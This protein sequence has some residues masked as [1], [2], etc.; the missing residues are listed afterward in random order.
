MNDKRKLQILLTVPSLQSTASP[1]RE[2]HAIA[3]FL[4]KDIFDLSICSLR[5][6]G[7]D[8][9]KSLFEDCGVKNIFKARYRINRFKRNHFQVAW[10]HQKIFQEYGP[11]DL[12]HSLDFSSSPFEPIMTMLKR[13]IY[14]FNQRDLVLEHPIFHR[15]KT[16]FSNKVIAISRAVENR[17]VELGV[18]KKKIRLIINGIDFQE[19]DQRLK[20]NIAV[21]DGLITF[22]G[23]IMPRKRHEDA[24]RTIAAL[25]DSG[26][27]VR[28]QIAGSVYDKNYYARLEALVGELGIK[29]RVKFLGECKDVFALL[30]KSNAFLLCSEREPIALSIQ[31]AMTIGVPVIASEVDGSLELIENG[32]SGLLVSVGDIAGYANALESLLKQPEFSK[33]LVKNARKAIEQKFSAQRMVQE[34]AELYEELISRKITN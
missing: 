29:E 14:I 2:I 13:R 34:Y 8:E 7:I 5:K 10:Q 28:L 11:F 24:I 21:E 26:L 20:S 23:H 19:I 3:K 30:R 31:E 17:L 6:T 9:S 27:N 18:N 15:I 33:S 16:A 1:Y 12:Q 22:I 32:K 4:P 25:V